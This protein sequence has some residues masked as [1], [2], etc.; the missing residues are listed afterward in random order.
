MGS[1]VAAPLSTYL[2]HEYGLRGTFLILGGMLLHVCVCGMLY[3]TP[4]SCH[5]EANLRNNRI[6]GGYC[7]SGGCRVYLVGTGKNIEAYTHD[8]EVV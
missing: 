1:F 6:S 8:S 3:R 7:I 2:L 4:E 5:R